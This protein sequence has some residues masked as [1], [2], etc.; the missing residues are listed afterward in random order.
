MLKHGGT[1]ILRCLRSYLLL[2]L[3]SANVRYL[4]CR[5]HFPLTDPEDLSPNVACD[6]FDALRDGL[7]DYT[8]DDRGDVGSWIRMACI[9]GLTSFSEV[10]F[11]NAAIIP[12]FEEYLLPSK[13]HDAVG[14]ILRQGVQRLD[15]V[16]QEAGENLIRLLLL[17][18][19]ETAAAERWRIHGDALMKQL[20]LKWSISFITL[21][22]MLMSYVAKVTPSV[23][24]TAIRCSQKQYDYW[25]SN[26]T[27]RQF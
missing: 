9:R 22:E 26:S 13:Y 14:G 5:F 12:N 15:S 27:A 24:K 10:L 18:L 2:S 23:G 21:S 17:P 25:R 11:S 16:R 6:L 4:S 19:P 7:E 1:A 3:G 20:F 8:M